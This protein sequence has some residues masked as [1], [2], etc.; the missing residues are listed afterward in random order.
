[1]VLSLRVPGSNDG[2]R[3]TFL[4]DTG[5][6][7]TKIFRDDVETIVRTS[8]QRARFIRLAVFQNA[9]GG[10]FVDPT[11]ELECCLMDSAAPPNELTPWVPTEV[12]CSPYRRRGLWR[13]GG[14]F[15]REMVYTA[16]VP[17]GASFLHLARTKT[18][19]TSNPFPALDITQSNI[20]VAHVPIPG[21]V[22]DRQ[23]RTLL[24]TTNLLP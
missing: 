4:D 12:Q 18:A 6:S 16:T 10:V 22:P 24:R 13:L 19:L 1:M 8:R 20:P 7:R 14:P 3:L 9:N 2:T 17:D 11:V 23:W 15:I 5:S 21:V